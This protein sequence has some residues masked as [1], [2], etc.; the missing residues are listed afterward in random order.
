MHHAQR[1]ADLKVGGPCQWAYVVD[2]AFKGSHA[3]CAAPD[4]R[5]CLH[6]RAGLRGRRDHD[7]APKEPSSFSHGD[8]ASDALD[9]EHARASFLM[10]SENAQ[11]QATC[12]P[13]SIEH[14]IADMCVHTMLCSPACCQVLQELR[15]NDRE[16]PAQRV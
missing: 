11:V 15:S 14:G 8:P 2:R 1:C 10:W 3:P 7:A 6:D 13:L 16:A 12:T 5:S 4:L 9:V